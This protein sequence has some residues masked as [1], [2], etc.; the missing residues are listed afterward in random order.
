MKRNLGAMRH[1]LRVFAPVRSPDGGGGFIRGDSVLAEMAAQ[2]ST[3]SATELLAYSNLQQRATHRA[4]IRY[5]DDIRQGQ[6]AV[7]LHPKGDRDLY[8]L[9][10][11]DA[12]PERPGEFLELICR[13]GGI[14]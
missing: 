10:A 9:T 2:I 1:R 3:I 5:R 6:S 4:I 11:I 12:R 13:E 7:W 14:T 8:I